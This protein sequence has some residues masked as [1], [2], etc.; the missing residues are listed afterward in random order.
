MSAKAF[1]CYFVY[2]RLLMRKIH[3]FHTFL[4][5]INEFSAEQ[6]F[7]FVTSWCKFGSSVER[8]VFISAARK[9]CYLFEK[10]ICIKIKPT[11]LILKMQNVSTAFQA[12]FQLHN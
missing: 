10:G 1:S 4:D 11:R 5:K 6:R 3:L 8:L 12:H 2:S 9:N 7:I